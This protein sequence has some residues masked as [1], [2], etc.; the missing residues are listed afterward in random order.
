MVNFWA[1]WCT[2]CREE[3]PGFVKLQSRWQD[4]GVQFV[5]IAQDDPAKVAA[6]GRELGVNYP[7]WLGEEGVMSLSRR[8][9]NRLG[10]LPHTVL[11]DGQ[12][13]VLESKIGVFA[14]PVLESRLAAITGK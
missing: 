9:G 6:F 4:R 11:L 12:G 7:L 8:L 14:E 3:M 1:T 10:V 5:G 2:P 13:R